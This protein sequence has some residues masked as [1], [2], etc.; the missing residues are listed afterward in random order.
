VSYSSPWRVY[1]VDVAPGLIVYRLRMI[2]TDQDIVGRYR[3]SSSTRN[4]IRFATRIIIE[5][6][7][8]YNVTFLVLI[9]LGFV[10][11]QLTAN[12]CQMVGQSVCSTC[13]AERRFVTISLACHGHCT[14]WLSFSVFI[15]LTAV[16]TEHGTAQCIQGFA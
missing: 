11:A 5:T 4:H 13:S 1:E 8:I 3:C 6:G 9:T 2:S 10:S 15:V 7:L 12:A 16:S 14:Y